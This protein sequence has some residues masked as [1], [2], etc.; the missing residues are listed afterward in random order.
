MTRL[1]ARAARTSLGVDD[2]DGFGCGTIGGFEVLEK[3]FLLGGDH[4][5]LPDFWDPNN[6]PDA[7]QIDIDADGRGEATG[8]ID[9]AGDDD[10]FRFL[11]DEPG[12]DF[13]RV[14][15]DT[16]NAPEPSVLDS[17]VDIYTSAG[18]LVTT[19]TDNGTL[20]SGFQTDGWVGFIA[21]PGEEYF[22]NVRSAV[23][24][25]P[26]T[27]GWYRVR[28]DVRSVDV[29]LDMN[30][31]AIVA[32]SI[33]E[34]QQ[35]RVFRFTTGPEAMFD[36]LATLTAAGG[37]D[38]DT[39]LDVYDGEGQFIAGDSQT[40]RLNDAFLPFRSAQD[41]T[42]YVRVRSDR[43]SAAEP[44]STG[45]FQLRIAAAATDIAISEETRLG[46]VGGGFADGTHSAL[47]R[48][49]SEGSGLAIV[50]ALG[51]GLPPLPDPA[52]R[53]FDFD[54]QMI[55]FAD[56]TFG[57]NPRIEQQVDGGETYFVI[58]DGFDRAAGGGWG[59]FIESHHTFDLS[60]PI[61]DH[62]NAGDFAN[63]T[64][65]RFGDPQPAPD[66][67]M[68]FAGAPGQ[69]L[70]D[71]SLVQIAD[72]TGR[73]HRTG[74]S[75]LFM[76]VPPVDMLGEFPGKAE[77]GD[78]A[79]L[80]GVRHWL[81]ERR[82]AARLQIILRQDF[83]ITVGTPTIRLL[84]SN[85]EEIYSRSGAL[86]TFPAPTVHGVLDPA[87]WP[88]EL[89]LPDG[90][91][92]EY[93]GNPF[94]EFDIW[95]GEPY[96]IE[97]S[98]AIGRYSFNV[99]VDAFPDTFDSTNNEWIDQISFIRERP[100][101]QQFANAR[102][103]V[104][105]AA[106]G[107]RFP[108]PGAFNG[109]YD[110]SAFYERA[111][112]M[113][114]GN[115]F[116]FM[117][118]FD[119]FVAGDSGILI[120]QESGMGNIHRIDDT[121]LFFFRAPATGTA[122]VRISTTGLEDSFLEFRTDSEEGDPGD[123]P[124]VEIVEKSKTID[125]LLD[126]ALRV[127]NNDF[128]EIAFNSRNLAWSPQFASMQFAQFAGTETF[129]ERDARAVFPVIGGEFYFI[130]VESGQLA[131]Y[132]ENP[133][134][135][136]WRHATGS[137]ELLISTLMPNRQPLGDDHANQGAIGSGLG[138]PIPINPTPG[139]PGLGTSPAIGGTINN[140]LEN[141]FDTDLFEFI[142]PG[143]GLV[144]FRVSA[145]SPTLTPA[146]FVSDGTSTIQFAEAGPG[147][148]AQA[149][150]AVEQ[151][152]RYYIV[153]GGNPA[154]FNAPGT[155]GA[156]TIELTSVPIT[157]D[158]HGP[159][160]RWAEATE[161]D[162]SFFFGAATASGTINHL[163][164]T[165]LFRFEASGF[166]L[167]Q[168]T[169]T[170]Q[171]V[172]LAPRVRV[173]EVGVDRIEEPWKP[174]F[175]RIVDVEASAAGVNEQAS[176]VFSIA[177]G[178]EYF[179][180]VEGAD[181]NE[182]TGS[183]GVQVT[184]EPTDDHPNLS[185]FPTATTIDMEVNPDAGLGFGSV[186]GEIE[187]PQDDDL[188]RFFAPSSGDVFVT[189]ATP[190]S[191][192]GPRVELRDDSANLI[193]SAQGSG[194]TAALSQQGV[195]Q[196]GR[197][198]YIVVAPRDPA[199]PVNNT[200]S[201][202]V[203]VTT[204]PPDDHADAGEWD[205]ATVITLDP[206]TGNGFEDGV[207]VP[208]FD[209]DLFTF[210]SI[211]TGD[212]TIDLLV[213]PGG[214]SASMRIFDGDRQEISDVFTP[215]DGSA[216]LRQVV[217][218]TSVG[219]RFYILI[220]SDSGG[221]P[222]FVG[223]YEIFV[224]GPAVGD[225]PPPPPG[226]GDGFDSP[227]VI[228]LDERTGRGSSANVI[229]SAGDADF[230][231]FTTLAPGNI[232]VQVVRPSG[233]VLNASVTIFNNQEEEIG[234]DSAGFPGVTAAFDFAAT[235]A[236]QQFFVVVQGVGDSVGSYE[237]RLDTEPMTHFLYHP[238]GFSSPTVDEFIPM[239][240]PN[241]FDVSYTI[242]AR[243]E[244][245]VRDEVIAT[246]VIGANSRGGITITTRFSDAESLTRVGEPYALEI[247]STGLLGATLSH[248][249]FGITTG[250]NFTNELST[251][252]TFSRAH[253]DPQAFRDF[254]V[255]YNPNDDEAN[256][257]VTLFYSDGTVV[258][259]NRSVEAFRRGGVAFNNDPSVPKDG[260]FGV[261]ITSNV[262]IVA[263][264]SSFDIASNRGFGTLGL[265][266]VGATRSA[267]P[268]I[269]SGDG[270]ETSITV[271]NTK[272]TATTVTLVASYADADLPNLTRELNIPAQT[273][274]VFSLS[275]LGFLGGQLAGI[276]F[277]SNQA[278]VIDA[279]E[280]QFGDGNS[281]SAI[282]EAGRSFLF[283]DAWIDP[284]QAGI[285]YIERLGLY[286]PSSVSTNVTLTFLFTDGTTETST[287]FVGADNFRQVAIDQQPA[288]LNRVNPTA[289]SLRVDSP[290]PVVASFMHY[291]LT[292]EGG[293]ATTGAP[294]GLTNLLRTIN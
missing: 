143:S 28:V 130:Q 207:I 277:T 131:T 249:D 264:I 236:G 69:T 24:S 255:F 203:N 29:A 16:I 13:V 172:D 81:D 187:I 142:A 68:E 55:A 76:F 44:T 94:A 147:G 205:Q 165:D 266:D 174:V 15:A 26:G 141:P 251:V 246:G 95:G 173:Y 244:T 2:G 139:N 278:V 254:L 241:D 50:D 258:T 117:F 57:L 106:G 229:D 1:A 181:P 234:S 289:F 45:N 86:L 115:R 270:V 136:D 5:S 271:L 265:P 182:H 215:G 248:Y 39:R 280:Y 218:A 122:E 146:V 152:L 10:L 120:L 175:L 113:G 159:A 107:I 18:E 123:F 180:L 286:N 30:G 7:T 228:D 110:F 287:V 197:A 134:E 48:F 156:Y 250:E 155:Q 290:I 202:I 61:D 193:A 17:R 158:D 11:F 198:Y 23:D 37:D 102:Q 194:G 47:F 190:N 92:F 8:E 235:G 179:V 275:D 195:L 292:L 171:S 43:V 33:D 222:P 163:G 213:P 242:V 240:N 167:A 284:A 52:L 221:D 91:P 63:A 217:E 238:E 185:D 109:V 124:D 282:S 150:F 237:V 239:V 281:V 188:F 6:P 259:F 220:G 164:D 51:L 101:D 230:F 103:L 231:T 223:S 253:R 104:V 291:D 42:W 49:T 128:Q 153:V 140:T 4:P 127:F 78:I 89:S 219:Q 73:L 157:V 67:F 96:Y 257:S 75:D 54:G 105:N 111:F 227:I 186:T 161:M 294:I 20:T 247:Q 162:V 148:T 144:T 274:R 224:D 98:G 209:T 119:P 149:T 226:T 176:A 262:P 90:A 118:P 283:G 160:Y 276:R 268:S 183:Y 22:I 31:A 206:A 168:V 201:Y 192:L 129:H 263:A 132:M 85:F 83:G 21:Q 269:T 154:D 204:A 99:Q 97:I 82:P 114:T 64:A 3:R 293:W 38:V 273:Q 208:S 212:I 256:L 65:L 27:T 100:G 34:L 135:V 184:F 53:M 41:S 288:I 169:V 196:A 88:A 80:F 9:P 56:D 191:N 272:S 74:D 177:P 62:A 59:V 214:L 200:G 133:D 108:S 216:T 189:V 72:G 178:R 77:E 71:R 58:L 40:G 14:I 151:G 137:Y 267:I 138:T 252:W 70:D 243:Y 66:L 25:G 87:S 36:S 125:S 32:G 46:S 19:G 260:S 261:M 232:F 79:D 279:V 245:G 121:D 145:Q 210:Q 233:S 285:N 35:D 166:D 60:Q 170:S 112:E 211:A 116:G 12:P 199:N 225:P 84:D 126:S 93:A